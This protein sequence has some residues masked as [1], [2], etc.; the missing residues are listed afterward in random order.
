MYSVIEKIV[1]IIINFYFFKHKVAVNPYL[2]PYH[3]L[4]FAS[5]VFVELCFEL[6]W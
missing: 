5:T 3:F 6:T 1:F 2:Y 4:T